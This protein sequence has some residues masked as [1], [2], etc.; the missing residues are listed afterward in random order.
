MAG[1]KASHLLVGKRLERPV[2]HFGKGGF[3]QISNMIAGVEAAENRSDDYSGARWEKRHSVWTRLPLAQREL[4]DFVSRLLPKK[5][6]QFSVLLTKNM[7][8]EGSSLPCELVC[9]ILFGNENDKTGRI[10][11][12]LTGEAHKAPSLGIPDWGCDDEHR[13]V[14][15]ADQVFKGILRGIHATS[16]FL[17]LSAVAIKIPIRGVEAGVYPRE[18]LLTAAA[19]A[20]VLRGNLYLE[21]FD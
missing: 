14:E 2:V 7:H 9:P 4:I 16:L 19:S 18:A 15:P 3:E 12:A 13:M 21:V 17:A 11:A 8:R 5:T 1:L 6:R 10:D 20:W